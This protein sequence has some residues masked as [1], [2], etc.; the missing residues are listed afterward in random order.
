MQQY[1]HKYLLCGL[2]TE[3]RTEYMENSVGD[4]AA[5]EYKHNSASTF[6]CGPTLLASR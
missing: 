5:F 6:K 3:Q 1:K 2:Q 4:F